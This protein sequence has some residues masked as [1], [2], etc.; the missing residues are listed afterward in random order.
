MTILTM[1]RLQA[2]TQTVSKVSNA[3]DR[4]TANHRREH[5]R[6]R[7]RLSLY[8]YNAVVA[9]SNPMM[10]AVSFEAAVRELQAAAEHLGDPEL[11]RINWESLSRLDSRVP[12]DSR[13]GRGD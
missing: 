13:S 2:F 6:E 4:C 12:S 11:S 8:F 7:V 1:P 5:A 9:T 10:L 3:A